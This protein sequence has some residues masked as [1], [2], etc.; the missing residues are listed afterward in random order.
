VQPIFFVVRGALAAI[1]VCSAW[2]AEPA[3][4]A[5]AVQLLQTGRKASAG[6]YAAAQ[7]QYGQARHDAPQYVRIPFAIALVAVQN[8]HL[9]EASKYLEQ[10]LSSGK[11]LLPLRRTRIWLD[12]RLNDKS[13]VTS[14]IQE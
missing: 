2:A 8:H 6:N 10:I 13:S 14:H 1:W 4:P 3:A 12:V 5:P 9:P 11:P 7:R